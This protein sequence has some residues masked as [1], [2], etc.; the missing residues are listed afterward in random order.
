MLLDIGRTRSEDER[1]HGKELASRLLKK[2][3]NLDL[4]ICDQGYSTMRW[5]DFQ[6]IFNPKIVYAI[7]SSTGKIK[8]IQRDQYNIDLATLRRNHIIKAPRDFLLETFEECL[9]PYEPSWFI[10]YAEPD[11]LF[12]GMELSRYLLHCSNVYRQ[13]MSDFKNIQ[14]PVVQVEEEST[15]YYKDSGSPDHSLLL[16]SYACLLTIHKVRRI[17]L[18]RPIK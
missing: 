9:D 17:L 11:K 3:P 14:K 1:K 7:S 8:N 16:F 13:P 6:G 2:W 18:R 12:D 5:K 15:A 10:P 4:I